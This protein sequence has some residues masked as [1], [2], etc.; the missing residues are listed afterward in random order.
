MM[1]RRV[2]ERG[3]GGERE[4]QDRKRKRERVS[5]IRRCYTAGFDDGQGVHEPRNAGSGEKLEKARE[6]IPLEPLRENGLA[7]TLILVQ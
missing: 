6:R 7:D 5:Y 2:R 3:E 1:E 4:R